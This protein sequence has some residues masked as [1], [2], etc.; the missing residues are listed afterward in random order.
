MVPNTASEIND[1]LNDTKTPEEMG[2]SD[3][4]GNLMSEQTLAV[5]TMKDPQLRR[6]RD[7]LI[8]KAPEDLQRID[9]YFYN[10][11]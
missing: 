3:A 9:L 4:V 8:R 11:R 1:L 6:V 2:L 10:C 5:M 7:A